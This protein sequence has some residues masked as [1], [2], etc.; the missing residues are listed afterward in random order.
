MYMHRWVYRT[1]VIA[2]ELFGSLAP[3]V[4]HPS[5]AHA[6]LPRCTGASIVANNGG[7]SVV[8]SQGTNTGQVSCA[9]GHGDRYFGVMVLQRALNYR[10]QPA[11][12][13]TA[14]TGLVR[15]EDRDLCRQVP[16]ARWLAQR[17]LLASPPRDPTRH[18][19]RRWAS[20][21]WNYRTRP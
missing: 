21:P 12:P 9:L 11:W 16:G 10:H 19:P 2:A 1:V 6:A 20:Q 13:R 18:A 15:A 14:S 17:H 8:P 7:T 4:V 5:P 3:A